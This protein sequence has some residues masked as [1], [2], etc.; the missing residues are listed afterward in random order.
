MSKSYRASATGVLLSGLLLGALCG[1]AA[2][3][4][5]LQI[6]EGGSGQHYASPLKFGTKSY[7]L[8]GTGLRKEATAKLYSMAL[9][10][11]EGARSS[12]FGIYERAGHRRAGL[13]IES[14]AQNFY[15]WGHFS[16][17][18]VLRYLRPVTHDELQLSFREAL[19]DS[20]AASAA[21]DVRKDALA[22][23]ALFDMDLKEG[24]EL[25]LHTDDTG[26]LDLYVGDTKKA[27]PH[28]PKLCRRIWEIWLGSHSISK[29][30]RQSLLDRVDVL[31]K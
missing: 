29:E 15:T 10:V 23:V 25:R 6:A 28:N 19:A 11:E 5:P 4:A 31:A 21:A 14:R 13:Y 9:Y 3:V 12:F 8:V 22:F 24:Q 2:A 7:I 20:L 17:L 30:M 26:Q 27:G 18:A 1:R 16:K